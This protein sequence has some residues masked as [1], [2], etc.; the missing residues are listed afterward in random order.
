MKTL[1][2]SVRLESLI[3]ISDKCYKAY[4]FNGNSDLIPKSQVLGQDY[5]VTKCEAYWISAWILERKTN[6]T[7]SGKKLRYFDNTTGREIPDVIIEKHVP[8]KINKNVEEN[9]E[10]MR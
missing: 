10:L 7:W 2:Y 6:I 3:N 5:E 1:Y 4:D 9:L 8:E